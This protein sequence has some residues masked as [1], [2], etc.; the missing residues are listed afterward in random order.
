MIFQLGAQGPIL[1]LEQVGREAPVPNFSETLIDSTA[2]KQQAAL[3]LKAHERPQG[4]PP[5]VLSKTLV[6][7]PKVQ[8]PL[9]ASQPP[10]LGRSSQ[11][12]KP[13]AQPILIVESGSPTQLGLQFPL[14][15]DNTL[16]GRD[17]SADIK[18]DAVAAD[19][20]RRQKEIR[21]RPDGV[22]FIVDL[23]SSNRN[24]LNRR[25]ITK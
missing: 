24:L 18:L 22:Y 1:S 16:L 5:L 10:T 9:A 2:A 21:R 23:K 13:K 6:D 20:S 25:I 14:R 15:D 11:V 19:V 3:R 12:P 8:V 7:K 17:V 4:L